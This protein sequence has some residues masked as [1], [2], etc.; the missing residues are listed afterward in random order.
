[1]WRRLEPPE[2]PAWLEPLRPDEVART[3]VRRSILATAGPILHASRAGWSDVAA[4][5]AT[6][7]AP[8][9]AGLAIVFAGLAYRASM[10]ERVV[11]ETPATIEELFGPSDVEGPPS[12][13][14]SV[15]EPEAEHVLTAVIDYPNP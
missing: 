5:W 2:W 10:P 11:A 7:L 1:M 9:A 14:T 12:F 13:L 4:R 6:L 15:S 8:A 3:R